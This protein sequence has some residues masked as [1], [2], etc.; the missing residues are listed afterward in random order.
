MAIRSPV[1][2]GP[3]ALN[4]DDADGSLD[5]DRIKSYF[6]DPFVNYAPAS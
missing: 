6:Q 3:M 5:P 4:V 1:A 2:T